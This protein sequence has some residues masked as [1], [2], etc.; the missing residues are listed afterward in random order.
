MQLNPVYYPN[1]GKS[2][3]DDIESAASLLAALNA[4]FGDW[5]VAVAAYNWGGGNV[6]HAYAMDADEYELKDMPPETQQYVI[7]V[8]ADVPG[9]GALLSGVSAA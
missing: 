5:Q 2:V 7:H 9:P 8:Y 1:A 6:H 3:T 4:R